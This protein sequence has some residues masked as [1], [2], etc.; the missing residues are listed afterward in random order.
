[1]V[2]SVACGEALLFG[3]ERTLSRAE[4]ELLLFVQSRQM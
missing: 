1:M 2:S 3:K 4:V